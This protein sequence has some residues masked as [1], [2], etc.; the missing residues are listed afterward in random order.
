MVWVGKS[1]RLDRKRP[2]KRVSTGNKFLIVTEGTVSEPIYFEL[3]HKELQLKTLDVYITPGD[4]SAPIHVIET[5]NRLVNEANP[6]TEVD[7]LI[8]AIDESLPIHRQKLP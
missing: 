4:H 5:A 8:R 3:L 2:K 7:R 6:S 1:Q